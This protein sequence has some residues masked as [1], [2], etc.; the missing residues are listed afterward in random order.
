[1]DKDIEKALLVV[2][3]TCDDEFVKT[4]IRRKLHEERRLCKKPQ[5]YQLLRGDN[6]SKRR[7]RVR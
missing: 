1:M 2:L 7:D 5:P 4:A 3:R 6:T